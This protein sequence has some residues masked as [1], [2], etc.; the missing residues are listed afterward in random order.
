MACREVSTLTAIYVDNKRIDNQNTINAFCSCDGCMRDSLAA[1]CKAL[2]VECE[3]QEKGEVATV[4]EAFPE[5][6]HSTV[7]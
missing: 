7:N 2:D 1:L 3:I 6:L 5:T 4:E